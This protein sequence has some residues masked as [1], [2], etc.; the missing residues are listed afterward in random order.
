MRDLKISVLAYGE[1][2]DEKIFLR[3]LVQLYCMTRLINVTTATA[4]GAGDPVE[5][6]HK[7]IRFRGV[8]KR[9]CHFILLDEDKVWSDEMRALA[10][11]ESIELV[12]N[13]PCLEAL[14]LEILNIPIPVDIG[15]GKCKKLFESQCITH[16][17]NEEECERLFTKS[18]LNKARERIP[19]LN[20]IINILQNGSPDNSIR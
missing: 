12:G 14:F 2:E 7:S 20:R 3:H 18:I 4:Q 10:E 6:V 19:K 15:S 1:G 13:K 11:V 16:N 5:I 17:F 8:E 9:D